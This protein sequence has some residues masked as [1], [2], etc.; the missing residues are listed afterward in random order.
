MQLPQPHT[1]THDPRVSF[2]PVPNR[3][4]VTFVPRGEVLVESL[5]EVRVKGSP[6]ARA[7]DGTNKSRDTQTT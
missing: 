4:A 2:L 5:V 6:K 3:S 7:N 1:H